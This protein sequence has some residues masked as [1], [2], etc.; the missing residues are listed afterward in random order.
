MNI[1]DKT[2][3]V[4]GYTLKDT[5]GNVLEST[6]EV[7]GVTYLHGQGLM[8]PKLEEALEGKAEGEALEVH[9]TAEEAYGARDENMVVKI[10]KTE[11]EDV[12]TLAIG[13]DIQVHDGQTG[14]IM[15]VVEI[16]DELVTLDGNHP[17]SGRDV[18]FD[19]LIQTIRETSQEDIDAL[20]AHHHDHEGCGCGHDHSESA[21][22]CCGDSEGSGKAE[23]GKDCC[24][25]GGGCCG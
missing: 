6:E 15:T 16:G 2:T 14:G 5:E 1:G 22:G 10:P 13:E 8:I 9:L 11:F 7:G 3:V 4:I 17:Y 24:G 18:V 25:S 20:Q 12:D 19:I 23:G 21:G